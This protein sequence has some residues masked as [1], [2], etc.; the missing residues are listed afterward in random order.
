MRSGISSRVGGLEGAPLEGC[1][2]KEKVRDGLHTTRKNKSEYTNLLFLGS[3]ALGSG[4]L[5]LVLSFLLLA[6]K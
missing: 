4:G 1:K 3:G 2:K 5:S 6:A